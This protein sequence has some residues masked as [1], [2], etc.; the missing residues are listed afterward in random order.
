MRLKAIV[1]ALIAAGAIS[2]AVG[3]YSQAGTAAFTKTR[4]TEPVAVATAQAPAA[5]ALPDFSALAERNS[6]AVVNITVSQDVLDVK[7]DEGM[8]QMPPMPQMDP[9]D[10]FYQ[11]FKRFQGPQGQMPRQTPRGAMPHH[12]MG[13]GFIISS[14]GL[15]LT[16]AHVV[17][18]AKEV[19]VKLTDK[20]EFK[21]KTIGFDRATDVAVIKVDAKDL[22][23]VVIGNPDLA[24]PGQWVV[25]IGSPFGM[26]NTVT[27]GIVS[28]KYR[29]LPDENYVPF[30]Q[31]DVA[32]NPG[33]S[34]GPLLNVRGEV[35][36]M[37]SQIYSHTGGYEGLSFAIPIDVVMKVEQQLVKYGKVERGRIGVTIQSLN[38]DLA[39][40]FGLEKTDGAL[41][42]SVDKDSP[43]A[44]AGLE[45]GDVIMKFNGE[46]V[47]ES[48]QL[49]GRVA[50]LKPG[51]SAKLEIWRKGGAKEVTVTLGAVK[52]AKVAS[53]ESAAK[54]QGKLGLAVRPLTP[55]EQQQ[56]GIKEGLLVENAD[57]PAARAGIQAGDVILSLNGTPV[58][59]VEQLRSLVSKAGKN[60]ALLVQRGEAKMFVPVQIG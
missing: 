25:A 29:A 50:D 30:I 31:T 18:G 53:D 44:K 8:P 42:S 11:F 45:P 51:T 56:S 21:A 38:Q 12:A 24:K 55:D 6:P 49:P 10:P 19:T 7:G 23:T 36:G 27:A 35:I 37:N 46:P 52:D 39:K 28:A 4:T 15:I 41:V 32:V 43:A 26:E 14:D 57:G 13:S 48:T 58:K 40:S 17:G 5:I 16:N 3:G 22:P 20:R 33:N 34:G 1:G 54:P 2:A 60:L 47:T 9:D 59:S